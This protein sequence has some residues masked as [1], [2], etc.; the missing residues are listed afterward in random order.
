MKDV[1]KDV[2]KETGR[3]PTV[4]VVVPVW[5]GATYLAEALQSVLQQEGAN[6][7]VIVVDDGSTDETAA[8]VQT[9]C[10]RVTYIYQSNQGP[11]AARNRGLQEATGDFIA[12][13]DADDRWTTDR[14]KRQL[15]YLQA[16][17][18]LDIV[19]EQIQYLHFGENGWQPHAEPFFAL[20]LAT[21]LF[22]RAVFS[23]VGLLDASLPYCEDVDWFFRAQSQGIAIAQQPAVAVYYRRHKHNLTNRLDLV[24]KYTLHVLMKHKQRIHK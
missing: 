18:T 6:L 2:M 21:A 5:N 9:F 3:Y 19:Q 12:F 15:T 11:A 23:Q 17:P 8:V 20:H 24:K 14:L 16:T 7:Q 13:I 4:S 1:M 22:R 10:P